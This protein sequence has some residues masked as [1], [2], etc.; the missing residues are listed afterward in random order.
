MVMSKQ[1]TTISAIPDEVE[2]TMT[3]RPTHHGIDPQLIEAA[4]RRARRERSAAAR[5]FFARLLGFRAKS[6]EEASPAAIPSAATQ[7]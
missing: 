4:I 5:A 6:R 1:D 7:H 3:Y 2:P